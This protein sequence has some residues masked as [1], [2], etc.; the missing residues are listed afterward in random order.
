MVVKKF[1]C[2]VEELKKWVSQ[3]SDKRVLDIEKEIFDSI[4]KSLS[5][6]EIPIYLH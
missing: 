3:C 4:E 1:K 6:Q 2:T 5:G